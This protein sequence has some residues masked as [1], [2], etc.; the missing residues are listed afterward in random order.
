[1]TIEMPGVRP[2]VLSAYLYP[3]LD[4]YRGFRRV[5]RNVYADVLDARMV[6]LLIEDLPEAD[7]RLSTELAAFADALE[8]IA[9]AAED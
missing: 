9:K 5:A 4:R 6:A 2:A 1:V 3:T 7:E 8:V